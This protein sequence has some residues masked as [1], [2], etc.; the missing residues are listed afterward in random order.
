MV[1]VASSYIICSSQISL[2]L[3]LSTKRNKLLSA[4]KDVKGL[5][6]SCVPLRAR[7][8]EQC[9]LNVASTVLSPWH[10]ATQR[11]IQLLHVASW[12]VSQC[13]SCLTL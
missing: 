1:Q 8:S 3:Q 7:V 2:L 13:I 5:H 4:V 12:P 9:S 6:L 10:N 11:Y